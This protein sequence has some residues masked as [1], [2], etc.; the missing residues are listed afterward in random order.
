M[1]TKAFKSVDRR[2]YAAQCRS[3]V[4]TL[5]VHFS[6]HLF[7][8]LKRFSSISFTDAAL[9]EHFSGRTTSHTE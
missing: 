8:D 4:C 2:V 7:K 9:F 5:E 3:G 1:E 6:S